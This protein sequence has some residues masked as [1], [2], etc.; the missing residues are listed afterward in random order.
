MN[1]QPRK[2]VVIGAGSVGCSYVYA[3]MQTGL[4]NE[5]VL[6]D[7]NEER[8][9]GEVMDLSHGLPFTPPVQIRVGRKIRPGFLSLRQM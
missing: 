9:A 5:I 1:T 3:L 7:S 8:V 4:A 2:V 6:I